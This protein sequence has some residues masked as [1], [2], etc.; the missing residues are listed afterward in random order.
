MI[1]PEQIQ[2]I[3][4]TYQKYGWTLRRVLI[5]DGLRVTINE[6][7]Q[8]LFGGAEII[9]SPFL[10]GL[11]FS[12]RASS[13]EG[14]EAWELRHLSESPFS[15]VDVFTAEDDDAARAERLKALETRLLEKTSKT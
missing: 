5:S 6:R 11:W 13:A 4:S 14:S 12:R 2:E 9:S 15:L 10:N 3:I 7:L 8:D 1:K